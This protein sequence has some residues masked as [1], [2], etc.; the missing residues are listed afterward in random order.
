MYFSIN[1]HLYL[2]YT[3]EGFLLRNVFFLRSFSSI[4]SQTV[5]YR[6]LMEFIAR[7]TRYYQKANISLEWKSW[8]SFLLVLIN[9]HA[10]RMNEIRI[11]GR[12][13]M[14]AEWIQHLP[15]TFISILYFIYIII[16]YIYV[17]YT[18]YELVVLYV[19]YTHMLNDIFRAK[20]PAIGK[21]V[22]FLKRY[23]G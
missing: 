16:L 5:W 12:F 8:T 23:I 9:F 17:S 22:Q 6:W 21:H 14:F 19:Y 13:I 7:R 1:M 11:V 15:F 2:I 3:F 18:Y 4:S 10:I 20:L